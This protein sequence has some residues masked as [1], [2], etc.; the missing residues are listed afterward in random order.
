MLLAELFPAS[1]IKPDMAA[2]TKQEL[3]DEL[4]DFLSARGLIRDK[5]PIL[6]EMWKRERMLDTVIAPSIALPHAS[7]PWHGKPVGAFGI[8]K[9]GIDY[10]SV[11]GK[12]VHIVLMLIDDRRQ[13]RA[14]VEILRGAA[15][16]I[17]TPNFFTRIMSCR[18]AAEVFAV[19][20][21]IDEIY[22]T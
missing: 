12:P 10:G 5:E 7:L 13:A 22:N 1:N 19:I 9:P 15:R 3:F 4:A 17:G 8:S 20:T 16:M 11:D 6:A 21:E 18:N 2:R 14:H